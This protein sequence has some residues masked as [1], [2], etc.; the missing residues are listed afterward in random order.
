MNLSNLGFIVSLL[1]PPSFVICMHYFDFNSVA[2]VYTLLMFLYLSVSFVYK[3]SLK[4]ISTPIIYFLFVL[5]A[6]IFSRIEF[7]KMI[8]AL[9][10]GSFFIFFIFSFLQKKEFIL[11]LTQKFYKK[12]LTLAKQ[13]FL[14]NSDGYWA[15]IILI[16]TLVQIGLVYNENNELWA[17]YSSVGWYVYL[18]VALAFQV[19]YEKLFISSRVDVV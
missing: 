19:V 10:S 16:N 2:F 3:Q 13:K 7:V 8:P 17:F 5:F 9:I 12:E 18:L 11:S 14:A 6:Y 1:F 15:V 4:S